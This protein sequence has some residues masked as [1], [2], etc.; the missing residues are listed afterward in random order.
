[1]PSSANTAS[2]SYATSLIWGSKTLKSDAQ[3]SS[4]TVTIKN[5]MLSCFKKGW[6]NSLRHKSWLRFITTAQQKSLFFKYLIQTSRRENHRHAWYLFQQ[7]LVDITTDTSVLS[8]IW[9][10]QSAPSNDL[11]DVSHKQERQR[12]TATASTH[13]CAFAAAQLW[14]DVT[15]G[16]LSGLGAK[17][18]DALTLTSW[19]S[20][21]PH[22]RHP[23][24]NGLTTLWL[25]CG[26]CPPVSEG[27][28]FFTKH[29]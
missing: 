12:E 29:K 27:V 9:K 26:F 6:Y 10:P 17:Q 8:L 13:Q 14:D 4:K 28:F 23:V 11:K 16:Q 2:S 22:V 19:P 24:S 20:V 15:E 18:S 21:A 3:R 5:N 1:M 25:C 7:L